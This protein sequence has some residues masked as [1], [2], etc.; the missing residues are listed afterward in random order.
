MKSWIGTNPTL[1]F[2]I[3]RGRPN[4]SNP[5][6]P[7][8]AAAARTPPLPPP[9]PPAATGTFASVVVAAEVCQARAYTK[10]GIVG[11]KRNK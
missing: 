10:N 2:V 11:I 4:S 7:L 8:D 9:P 6:P 3:Y 1:V 5:P